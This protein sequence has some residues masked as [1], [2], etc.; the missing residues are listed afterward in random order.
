MKKTVVKTKVIGA[1]TEQGLNLQQEEFC[2][3]FVMPDSDFYGNGVSSYIGAYKPRKIGNWYNVARA[4]S[5]RLLTNVNVCKRINELLETGGFNSENID[6]Q[7][8]FLINQYADLKTKLGAIKE[9]NELKG[10]VEKRK[11]GG[12]ATERKQTLIQIL[13]VTQ[14]FLNGVSNTTNKRASE[15]SVQEL[16]R[17]AV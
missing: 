10:R 15:K 4:C 6:K 7:H 11:E 12:E 17:R 16:L 5:S 2:Q 13:N 14:N 9:F 3:L 8:L 1:K